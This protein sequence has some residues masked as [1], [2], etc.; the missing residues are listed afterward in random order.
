MKKYFINTNNIILCSLSILLSLF[1]ACDKEPEFSIP[2]ELFDINAVPF[3]NLRE[4]NFFEGDIADLEPVNGIVLY[5]LNTP[6]FSN[7]A[8]K[9]R[10]VYLPNGPA[11]YNDDNVFEFPVGSVIIKNFYFDNDIRNP[12]QGRKIIE[13][14][15]LIHK[16]DGWF[17]ASYVWND[18]QTAAEFNIVG[19]SVN[20][21]WTHYD[22]QEKSI[23]Y[24]VPNKNQCKGCHEF[25][26]EL[27]PIGPKARNLNGTITYPNGIVANQLEQWKE[28]DIL[29]GLPDMSVVSKAPVWNDPSTGSLN[30][31]ARAYIDINCAHCH[32]EEGP[33][34]NSGLY[35][36]YH[37]ELSTNMGICKPPVAAGGG[38]GGRK[39][40]IVPGSPDESIL[41]YRLESLEPDVSM[42]ELSRS[43]VDDEGLELLREWINELD[44]E[45]G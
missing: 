30:D 31:R 9:K 26:K 43:V 19:R 35:M 42:P 21:S 5:E 15:L 17:P 14:R 27:V 36:N 2:A 28:W 12:E 16:E 22:G 11:T 37:R 38:S 10:F 29:S 23:R 40:A 7:Y 41:I 8:A 44:G 18:E 33:A 32:S 3:E 13:T 4:Y 1:Y 39:F 24:S 25:N 20:L 34:N 45:C 6:L